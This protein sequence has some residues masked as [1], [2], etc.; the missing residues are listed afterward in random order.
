MNSNHKLYLLAFFVLLISPS[1]MAEGGHAG[2]GGDVVV[3][4]NPQNE[5]TSIE[6]L[7][8]Y[9]GRSFPPH[10]T[11][12]L[13]D[14][15][16]IIDQKIE[17]ALQRLSR[18]DSKRA[19]NYRTEAKTFLEK[20]YFESGSELIDI[21]DSNHL[22]YPNGCKVEQIVIAKGD[23]SMSEDFW[24]L[25]VPEGK[26]YVVNED[27][28]SNPLFS[29]DHKAGLIL[30]EIIYKEARQAFKHISSIWSRHFNVMV[31]ST[32][33]QEFSTKDY[34]QLLNKI[35]FNYFSHLGL[36]LQTK[37]C[38][39]Y[40]SGSIQSANS[41]SHPV[42][43]DAAGVYNTIKFF[44]TEWRMASNQRLEF[45]VNGLLKQFFIA[46]GFSAYV[47]T[48]D[49]KIVYV[50]SFAFDENGRI[51]EVMRYG[52]GDFSIIDEELSQR[53]NDILNALE[54]VKPDP[55][56][57]GQ[58]ITE[59]IH[60]SL[61]SFHGHEEYNL[62]Q[63]LLFGEAFLSLSESEREIL[64]QRKLVVF[65]QQ[66]LT[67]TSGFWLW[68][69]KEDEQ[70]SILLNKQTSNSPSF[71]AYYLHIY[72]DNNSNEQKLITKEQ[73]LNELRKII[74]GE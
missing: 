40:D 45:Y 62:D 13:G 18:L 5:I 72:F 48:P 17:I 22:M 15:S 60:F 26:D 25:W 4:R 11:P 57:P 68:S 36:W 56:R 69:K 9:E 71:Y 23:G 44:G 66:V 20:A 61:N 16:L 27:L 6:L 24:H 46:Y 73:I 12:S 58:T 47:A 30:H 1:L 49:R 33:L 38:K 37:Y 63:F 29:D 53:V 7:D 10:V 35:K 31:S 43:Y 21:P 41:V 32:L 54:S 8:Y 42:S 55:T 59:R 50:N 14:A 39:F 28:W 19:E 51:T 64:R 74:R 70:P 2:N 65:I 3:C 52:S 34:V 67:K